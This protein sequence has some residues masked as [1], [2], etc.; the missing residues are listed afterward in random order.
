MN[1]CISTPALTRESSRHLYGC[2]HCAQSSRRRR[3]PGPRLSSRPALSSNSQLARDQTRSNE[4]SNAMTKNYHPLNRALANEIFCGRRRKTQ[5]TDPKFNSAPQNRGDNEKREKRFR[6]RALSGDP[7]SRAAC[8]VLSA[9]CGS[10]FFV[11][12]NLSIV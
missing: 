11:R 12:R 4:V 9:D 3:P 10:S 2:T 8:S 6:L 1:C 7:I 5:P